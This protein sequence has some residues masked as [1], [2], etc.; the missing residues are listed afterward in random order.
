MAARC[1]SRD[2][3]AIVQLMTPFPGAAWGRHLL[4]VPLISLGGVVSVAR[5]LEWNR[6]QRALRRG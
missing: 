5:Y 4:A 3:L 1:T 6:D 2:Q